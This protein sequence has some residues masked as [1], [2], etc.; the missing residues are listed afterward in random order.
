[1]F[2]P[3]LLLAIAFLLDQS[4]QEFYRP[5]FINAFPIGKKIHFFIAGIDP[6][7]FNDVFSPA[8]SFPYKLHPGD[9]LK[10]KFFHFFTGTD[11][12]VQGAGQSIPLHRYHF[13]HVHIIDGADELVNTVNKHP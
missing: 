7:F 11:R 8:L 5:S 9:V 12:L 1:M 4:I 10:V 6:G 2:N 3:A 13:R